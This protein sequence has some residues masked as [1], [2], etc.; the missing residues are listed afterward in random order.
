MGLDFPFLNY[1]VVKVRIKLFFS[2]IEFNVREVLIA[3][4]QE[5]DP[6]KSPENCSLK[7]SDPSRNAR[8][9]NPQAS[10]SIKVACACQ[11]YIIVPKNV[12]KRRL[13]SG[14]VGV[15]VVVA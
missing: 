14:E 1:H 9:W 4:S 3:L 11:C 2:P 8:S 12:T 5:R 13:W 15:Y 7:F 10:E 6:R